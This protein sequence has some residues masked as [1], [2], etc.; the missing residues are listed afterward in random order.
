MDVD[1]FEIQNQIVERYEIGKKYAAQ[2]F[3]I[4]MYWLSIFSAFGKNDT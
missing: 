2:C 3:K 4:N 1:M